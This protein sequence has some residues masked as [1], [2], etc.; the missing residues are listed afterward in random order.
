MPLGTAA[1][2]LFVDAGWETS[3]VFTT[4][5]SISINSCTFDNIVQRPSPV[6]F[7]PLSLGGPFAG[8]NSYNGLFIASGATST[9]IIQVRPP[10]ACPDLECKP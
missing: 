7:Q 5:G 2:S 3:Q 10:A 6:A 1:D 8:E 4:D 9:L